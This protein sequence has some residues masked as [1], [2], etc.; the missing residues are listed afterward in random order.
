MMKKMELELKRED[1]GLNPYV[2]PLLNLLIA[3][4]DER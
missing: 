4:Y 2:S 1:E 3:D